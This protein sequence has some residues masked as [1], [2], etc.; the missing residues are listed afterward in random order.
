MTRKTS[1]SMIKLASAA[2]DAMIEFGHYIFSRDSAVSR[3]VMS[4]AIVVCAHDLPSAF[5]TG[6][7]RPAKR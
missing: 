5:L 1:R 6:E 3:R 7:Y 2:L 4:L